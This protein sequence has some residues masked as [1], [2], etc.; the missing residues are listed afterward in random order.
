MSSL[1]DDSNKA[2]AHQY[3]SKKGPAKKHNNAAI[4][5]RTP[6]LQSAAKEMIV[7]HAEELS[8]PN[9][10]RDWLTLRTFNLSSWELLRQ[11]RLIRCDPQ[12]IV[13]FHPPDY[14]VIEPQTLV[15]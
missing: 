3:P 14:L 2:E 5:A 1:R 12:K 7:G 10:L 4:K 8:A 13:I 6:K 11:T 15:G 9:S